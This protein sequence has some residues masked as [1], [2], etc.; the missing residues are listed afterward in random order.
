[1]SDTYTSLDKKVVSNELWLAQRYLT[2][3][4]QQQKTGNFDVD[5]DAW[6]SFKVMLGTIEANM[7]T[8]KVKDTS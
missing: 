7:T 8:H 2:E 3:F 4:Y 6:N 5:K 1:M